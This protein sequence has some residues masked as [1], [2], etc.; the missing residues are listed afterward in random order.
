MEELW[1]DVIGHEGIYKISNKGKVL[2][3]EGKDSLGRPRKERIIKPKQN[4]RGYWQIRLYKNGK[5]ENWLLHRL[6]AKNFIENPNNLSQVNHKDENKDNNTP[7]NLEW[8]DNFYNRH[9][10]TGILRMAAHKDYK[11]SSRKIM[12]AIFQMNLN[13]Q[14]IKRFDGIVEAQ[15]ETNIKQKNISN[16]VNKHSKTAGGYKW[17]FVEP[18]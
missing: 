16:C 11:S 15:R 10:G 5:T 13:G 12:K 18:L 3:I 8:C 2:R 14:I 4:N 1:K 7:E 9:Y 6:V 17:R